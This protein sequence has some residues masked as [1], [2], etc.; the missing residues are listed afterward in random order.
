MITVARAGP[1]STISAKNSMKASA[2]QTSASVATAAIVSPETEP[3]RMPQG[4]R[5][6]GRGVMASEP[7]TTP[8][9]GRWAS[10]RLMMSGPVA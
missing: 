5:R 3:G 1:T 4:E 6:V 8:R 2:V 9:P 10:R 7:V